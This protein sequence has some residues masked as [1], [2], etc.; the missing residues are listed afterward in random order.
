MFCLFRLYLQSVKFASVLTCAGSKL[1][2]GP[3][4]EDRCSDHYCA[5]IRR[6]PDCQSAIDGISP[7]VYRMFILT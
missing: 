1:R 4:R 5:A 7:F 3:N 6:N 2:E